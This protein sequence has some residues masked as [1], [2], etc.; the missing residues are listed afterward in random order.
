MAA[1]EEG[2]AL[3]C[4]DVALRVLAEADAIPTFGT[5]ALYEALSTTPE[6]ERLPTA[7]ELKMRLLRAQIAGILISLPEPAD[8]TGESEGHDIAVGLFLAR[9]H[10]RRKN[11][12]QPFHW[13]LQRLRTLMHGPDRQTVLGLRHAACHGLGAAVN[14]P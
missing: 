9:P 11:P 12:A 5:R 3:W 2:S 8:E 6:G 1:S 10:V 14:P 7:H 13:C 4:D